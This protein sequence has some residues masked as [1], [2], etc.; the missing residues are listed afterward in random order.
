MRTGMKVVLLIAAGACLCCLSAAAQ[1]AAGFTNPLVARHADPWVYLHTDGFYYF[2]A[3]VP[4]YD[5]IEIRKSETIGGLAAARPVVI[6]KKHPIGRMGANIWAP[7][8]HFIDGAWY[9]YFAA[10][11]SA[12]PYDVRLYVLQNLSADPLSAS[13]TEKGQLRTGWDSISV[14]ATTFACAGIRYLV[15]AQR[16]DADMS[17]PLDLYIA[18]M[19]NPWTIAGSPEL[20]ST[21]DHLWELRKKRTRGRLTSSRTRRDATSTI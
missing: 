6:W 9:V 14:D 1:T 17:G 2:C 13:W 12:A 4:E 21:A 8:L 18:R 11:S 15:W 20:L 5:R 3:T 10:G 16:K 19:S 7:E